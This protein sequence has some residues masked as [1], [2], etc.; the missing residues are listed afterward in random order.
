MVISP[1]DL[2]PLRSG[3]AWSYDV[4]TGENTHT[5]AITR[6]EALH[7]P[8]AIVRTGNSSVKY[9]LR[10]EGIYVTA[11]NAWLFRLPFEEGK[12]WPA[13]GGRTGRMIS[14]Q[15]RVE[16]PAGTFEGCLEVVETGGERE[17]EV[18]TI[19]CPFVGPVAVDST[20]RSDVSSREVS[21]R[22]RLRGYDV[23]GGSLNR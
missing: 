3:N 10:E 8:I 6:V 12:T 17:L 9:E 4:D 1:T 19:Y 15:A 7:G 13:R 23:E 16:T 11:D 2:Y 14:T 5:L 20:M 18:R 21:V 22:A